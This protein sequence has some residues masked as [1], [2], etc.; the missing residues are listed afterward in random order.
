MI[1]ILLACGCGASSGFIAQSMRKAA[2]AKGIQAQIRAV[3]D[4][5]VQGVI[6]DY[7]VLLLGPHIG[8][9]LA[10]F[11]KSFE[12]ENKIIEVIDQRHYATL[13]G[14]EVLENILQKMNEGR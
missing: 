8:Y 3:S 10:E 6:A 2:K 14:A 13:N 12:N 7:D 1:N 9:R 4:T 5:E 11:R